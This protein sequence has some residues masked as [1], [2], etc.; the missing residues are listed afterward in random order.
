VKERSSP[1]GGFIPPLGVMRETWVSLMVA[2]AKECPLKFKHKKKLR[3]G[4][5]AGAFD[6]VHVGHVAFALQA[7]TAAQL[8]QVVFM[9]ERRPRTKPG[10]E[11]YG[12][13]V[14]MLKTA[15]APYSDL[16]VMEVVD[17][18]FTVARTLPLLEKVFPDAELMLLMG[19]DA[20]INLPNWRYAEMLLKKTE[21]VIGVR[22]DHDIAVIKKVIGQWKTQP[23]SL[24]V[25]NSYA[26]HVSSSRVRHALRTNQHA[27]G[28]LASVRRYARE[29]W[30]Y[31][32]PSLS[33]R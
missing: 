4:I 13:R 31:V 21:L 9:P 25:F 11:H 29:Q 5:Y 12:H 10:V 26:S 24:T 18:H 27:E 8:D 16:A 32:S 1:S 23:A 22:S 33:T 15:L 17:R 19:S 30:L 14:A 2:A 3:I 6:P 7:K 20:A 28:L